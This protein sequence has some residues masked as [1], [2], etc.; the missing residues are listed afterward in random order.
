MVG[1]VKEVWMVFAISEDK[2]LGCTVWVCWV[3]GSDL[4]EREDWLIG[5][6]D[7]LLDKWMCGDKVGEFELE[8][9]D[10][11]RVV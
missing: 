10:N 7:G 5:G 9:E 4:G 11:G 3:V 1:V 6:R 2:G 8:R